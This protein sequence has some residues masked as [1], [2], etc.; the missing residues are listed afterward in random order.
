VH[1]VRAPHHDRQAERRHR[2]RFSHDT[3]ARRN[4]ERALSDRRHNV[5]D[6]AR[7]RRIATR[8]KAEEFQR[9]RIRADDAHD[10]LRVVRAGERVRASD[11]YRRDAGFHA[12]AGAAGEPDEFEPPA[13]FGGERN[14]G[15]NDRG[16][17][18]P[19]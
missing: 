9:S 14:I 16:D 5:A 18:A 15:R 1:A 10:V 17:A 11:V 12:V 3:A 13:A 6:D 7:G 4:A 19:R 2:L 8:T